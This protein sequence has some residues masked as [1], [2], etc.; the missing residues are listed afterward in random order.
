MAAGMLVAV[1]FVYPPL[2]PGKSGRELAIA[3]KDATAEP[4]AAGRPVLAFNPTRVPGAELTNVLYTVNFYSDGVYLKEVAS[5][6]ELIAELLSGAASFLLADEAALPPLPEELLAR[7][8]V[9][10]STRLS[11][12]DLLL[13]RFGE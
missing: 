4:R 1:S 13:L 12:K 7:M 2:N 5:A 6:E 8:N 10:Y 9:V 3:V 11:R